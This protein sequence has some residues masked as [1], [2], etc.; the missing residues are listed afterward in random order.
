MTTKPVLHV[1]GGQQPSWLIGLTDKRSLFADYLWLSHS[2]FSQFV[3]QIDPLLTNGLFR[4][5]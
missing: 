1:Q 3:C 4:K 2:I 5:R